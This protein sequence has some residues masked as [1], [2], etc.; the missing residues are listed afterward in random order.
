ML[1]FYGI[2]HNDLFLYKKYHIANNG[3]INDLSIH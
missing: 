3:D 2:I 1:L